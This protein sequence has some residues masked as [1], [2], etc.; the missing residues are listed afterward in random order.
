MELPQM[1]GWGIV[2]IWFLV[3]MLALWMRPPY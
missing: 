2:A 3:G 1:I